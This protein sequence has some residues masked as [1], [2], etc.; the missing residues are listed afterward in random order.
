MC[1]NLDFSHML[2]C[3]SFKEDWG[4]GGGG[5]GG[6]KE[7]T[8]SVLSPQYFLCYPTAEMPSTKEW[9]LPTMTIQ[10]WTTPLVWRVCWVWQAEN[11]KKEGSMH[12][13]KILG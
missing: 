5:G 13:L 8:L 3:V 12:S 10:T 4:G 11:V 7:S 2:S 9:K 1:V 6:G